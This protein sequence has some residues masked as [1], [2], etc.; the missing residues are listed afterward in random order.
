MEEKSTTYIFH[1]FRADGKSLLLHPFD[2][3]EKLASAL[4]K[5]EIIGRYGREPHIQTLMAFR[6]E[7]YGL[8]DSAVRRRLS[9][10]RF[11]PKFLLSSL[12]FFLSYFIFSYAVPDPIPVIDELVISLAIGV[13]TYLLLGRRDARSQK[14][15][16]TRC[17]FM[18][19]VDRIRFTESEFVIKAEGALHRNESREIGDVVR[20]TIEPS[21]QNLTEEEREEAIQFLLFLEGRFDSRSMR[22]EEKL[23]KGFALD[24][25]GA[26]AREEFAV[27]LRARGFDFP[28]YAVYKSLKESVS[29]RV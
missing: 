20:E 27:R 26:S 21:L 11:I 13:L 4:E 14:A 19:A 9:N 18:E 16:L 3:P 12:L 23:L 2:G 22:R 7:A 8:V 1:V 17:A 29:H 25:A 10:R 24:K 15:S 28:L 5:G 6:E